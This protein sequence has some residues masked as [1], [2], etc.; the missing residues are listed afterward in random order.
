MTDEDIIKAAR[1]RMDESYTSE[2]P[3]RERAEDDMRFVIGD[4]YDDEER[5]EREAEGRP[6]LT[7]NIMAQNVRQVTGQIRSLNPAIR[8]SPA[9]SAANKDT[10][11][12]IEGMIRH[13]E[14]KCD[15]SSVYEAATE[16]AAAS[17]IGYWR[18]RADYCDE[19]TFDQ[20]I[21]IER[22]YNPFAVFLDPFA[23]HPTRKD[24]RYGFIVEEMPRETFIEAYPKARPADVT[25][26]HKLTGIE[27]W[28][29]ADSVVV[30]EYFWIEHDEYEVVNI[31]GQAVKV[32]D[33]PPEFPK[34]DPVTGRAFKRRTVRKPKVMWAK[35]SAH[36]VLEGP[37]EFPS[38]YIPIIAVTGEEWHLG[39]ETY[40]SSVIRFAK[41]PQ[42][43]Y[44]YAVSTQA[45]VTALQP[46]AP[47]MVATTQ[48]AG[49]ED[50]WSEAGT[51]NRAYLP[52]VPDENVGAPQRVS[53]PIA[54]QALIT[55][56]QFAAEDIK[57]TT[58]IY[59]ASLGARS[60]ETS[61]RAILARK[62]ESQ[63]ATS[64][65]SD[66]MVKAVQHT[67]TIIVDMIPRIYDAQ[68]IVRVLGED[69]QE[70]METINQMLMGQD[71]PVRMNDMSL[72]KYDVRI[73]VG[74]SYSSKREETRAG[75]E[76][77]FRAYPQA[78]PL[79][80]DLYAKT[81]E[82]TDADRAA[83]RLRKMLPPGVAEEQEEDMSP[84]Q[85]QAKQAQMQ[86]QQAE[87][88]MQQEAQEIAKA[89]AIAEAKE[90]DADARKAAAE[91]DKAE[92][93][94][95]AMRGDIK[96]LVESSVSQAVAT[97]VMQRPVM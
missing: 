46:K 28:C 52:Y 33:L 78:A 2:Q 72:G 27:Q 68:R 23:K 63:N 76:E 92:I 65:Y 40:R 18:V 96:A 83:E 36:D 70:K 43:L 32:S 53:P 1:E 95:A 58:G 75:M 12:V 51:K 31:N 10:A 89:K 80:G 85:V 87:A 56:I 7:I 79:L 9:D 26:D 19:G 17:S 84:E 60:N 6:C 21:L 94:V 57:R 13:I 74:P 62:E 66:N 82:W 16:S 77:F 42:R 5:R 64:I 81:L 61:G 15:A 59:D 91:A 86:Q 71:G 93:E 24:A 73:A 44:N 69:G 22:V 20:E 11:S 45:E 8:V 47:F 35:I 29:S 37:M 88:A 14:N 48:I 90:A 50:I 41:E 4:Q 55:Q 67:G 3:H 54:S 34:A 25:S 49:L 30:A 39:E 97:A 38:R